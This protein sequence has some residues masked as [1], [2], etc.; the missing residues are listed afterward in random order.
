M[1][2]ENAIRKGG[3]NYNHPRHTYEL[4]ERRDIW[5]RGVLPTSQVELL[6]NLPDGNIP[7]TQ[8]SLIEKSTSK[9]LIEV[10]DPDEILYSKYTEA[11]GTLL[12][13]KCV[14]DST[15]TELNLPE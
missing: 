8:A 5:R 6:N 13:E 12:S 9:C 10:V 3:H 15:L 1:P 4:D 14:D 11:S 2:L 7:I